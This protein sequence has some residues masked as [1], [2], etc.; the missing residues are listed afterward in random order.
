MD[1]EKELQNTAQDSGRFHHNN[2]HTQP[3]VLAL[4]QK[5]T[6]YKQDDSN[7]HSPKQVSYDTRQQEACAKGKKNKAQQ[8]SFPAHAIVPLCF[9]Y[10]Q[11][12]VVPFK[13]ASM[14][15]T[16]H[17]GNSYFSSQVLISLARS[18]RRA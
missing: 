13:K 3:P 5:E 9:Q 6:D 11:R 15:R 2:S 8:V 1:S 17:A 14:N 16:V 18:Y 12:Q 4:F 10:T 7:D